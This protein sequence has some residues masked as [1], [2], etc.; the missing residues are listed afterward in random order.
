[1]G[2]TRGGRGLFLESKTPNVGQDAI[3]R[4]CQPR[5]AGFLS[6][7]TGGL[8]TRRRM[9]SCPTGFDSPSLI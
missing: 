8:A 6:T 3:W 9:A 4:G 1:V 5:W 7:A 2:R